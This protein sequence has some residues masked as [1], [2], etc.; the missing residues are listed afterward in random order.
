MIGVCQTCKK[1]SKD[2]SYTDIWLEYK[3]TMVLLCA[4]CK[5]NLDT[6]HTQQSDYVTFVIHLEWKLH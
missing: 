2:V 4:K 3:E 6:W 1:D 5:G